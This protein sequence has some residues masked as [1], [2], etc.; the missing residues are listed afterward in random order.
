MS[1]EVLARR[2]RPQTFDEVVGQQHVT[3]TL[4]NAIASGRLPHALLL[5]GPRGIGKTT[6]ARLVA[7]AL[8]CDDGPTEKPCGRCGPCLEIS[9]GGSMDVQE[10]DAASHTGVDNVRDIIETSRY[11]PTPGKHRIFIIDEIHMLSQPAFNALL[12]TLEEPPDRTLFVFATTDPQKIPATVLSRVQRFDL[13]RLGSAEMLE[14]LREIVRADEI[15]IPEAVLRTIAREADGSLRDSLTLLDRLQS[16][17]GQTISEADAN[18]V[19]D[20]VDRRVREEILTPVLA[21]DAAGALAAVRSAIDS[22]VDPSRLSVALLS[23]LRDL[24]VARI[25]EDAT[26]V[27]DA[28]PDQV[29]A[30]QGR[31]REHAAETFQQLFRVLLQRH[32]D[33]AWAPSPAHALEMAVARLATLPQTESLSRLIGRLEALEDPDREPPPGSP[34]RPGRTA[35][36]S[37]RGDSTGSRAG[38]GRPQS[39][40]RRSSATAAG[41]RIAETGPADAARTTRGEREARIRREAKA[42]PAVQQVIES[43][44]GELREIRIAEASERLSATAQPEDEIDG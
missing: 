35:G 4:R 41:P 23:D 43:L 20:L 16:G 25:V 13:R 1:Y 33:L 42:H 5:A 39:S 9:S 31:A 28:A 37:T 17:L 44:D 21:Q 10:I 18:A 40:G 7:K 38:R 32:Q 26:D 11:A 27:I 15:E 36:G 22:G 2:T 29:A 8:N 3:V 24:L 14:R 12:K 34:P 19:L 6:I 30:V